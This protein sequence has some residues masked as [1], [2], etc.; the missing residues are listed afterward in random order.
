MINLF[1]IGALP[2]EIPSIEPVQNL[3][4]IQDMQKKLLPSP[5]EEEGKKEK[6]KRR[7]VRRRKRE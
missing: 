4:L 7:I 6:P 2:R 5:F 1:E 3:A